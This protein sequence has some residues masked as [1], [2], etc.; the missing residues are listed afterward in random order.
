MVLKKSLLQ[1]AQYDSIKYFCTHRIQVDR[2]NTFI[3]FIEKRS[4][5][6]LYRK[7]WQYENFGSTA[8]PFSISI[9]T[10]SLWEFGK[11]G[12]IFTKSAPL[13]FSVY[14]VYILLYRF[15]KFPATRLLFLNNIINS[16]AS[17][18]FL[19]ISLPTLKLE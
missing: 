7:T 10:K 11:L 4:Y 6:V 5:T 8:I 3:Q 17:V 1:L 13:C 18:L 19:L 9:F 12:K 14:S 16:S 2:G 15:N